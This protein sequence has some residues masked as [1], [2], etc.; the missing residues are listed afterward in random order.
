MNRDTD[1][2]RAIDERET[3]ERAA[4]ERGIE[5][6]RL[7]RVVDRAGFERAT[8]FRASAE[9]DATE[10]DAEAG[11]LLEADLLEVGLP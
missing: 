3:V 9:P 1:V 6:G 5:D 10:C 4:E 11:T 2:R 7:E 8:E